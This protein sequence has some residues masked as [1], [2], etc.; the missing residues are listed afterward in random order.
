M[1]LNYTW[2]QSIP[3]PTNAI[4]GYYDFKLVTLS[5][6][7]AVLASYVA[8]NLVGRLRA[9][10]NNRAKIYWLVGGAFA[11]GAGIW[12]MHFIGMLAFIM[13]MPMVYD[14]TWTAASLFVAMLAS[15]LALS[16]LQK[17][18]LSIFYLGLGGIFIGFG[19][20]TMHYM[21]MEGMKIHVDIKY[22]PGL[23]FL[24]IIIAVAAAEAA[25]WLALQSNQGSI[26][27]Q[28]NLK[29]ISALVMGVA[30]CG[31]HYTGMAAAVFTPKTSHM[32]TTFEAINPNYLAFFVAGVASLII[33]MALM[34]STYY[35]K[36]VNA[37]ENEKEFLNAMLNNLEDGII[38]CDAEG[39]ITVLNQSL[40]KKINF[41][42]E[43]KHIDDLFNYFKL[44]AFCK[45]VDT[46]FCKFRPLI[47]F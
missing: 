40:Q 22:L 9:E 38:A 25:L 12:S 41:T 1:N 3:I 47:V 14:F 36:M 39:R 5:Y 31:M 13:P 44:S 28:F 32:S 8:L 20:A 29:I 45:L 27:R 24:S 21:G 11:M 7:V 26:K 18:N 4:H 33:S 42:N 19:I 23:F 30:I 37:V 35:K 6:I 43:K 2:F 34:A 16:I 17:N 15:G 46:L 10:K